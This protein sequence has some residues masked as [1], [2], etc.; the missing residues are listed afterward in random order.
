MEVKTF[1]EIVETEAPWDNIDWEID[2]NYL[3][4]RRK[5]HKETFYNIEKHRM[6]TEDQR[7]EWLAQLSVKNWVDP[8]LA[9]RKIIEAR[10][11][12]NL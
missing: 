6:K 10:D 11:K 12:W 3:S 7:L 9:M 2:D 5:G 1:K 4:A 8:Y